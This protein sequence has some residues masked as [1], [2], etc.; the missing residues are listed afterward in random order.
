[1][2]SKFQYETAK[3]QV[4]QKLS[5]VLKYGWPDH[6][7]QLPA[8]LTPYF[9]FRQEITEANRII[10]KGEQVT[11]PST[12][13]MNMKEK[14]H[15]RRL[16]IKKCKSRARETLF[17][18]GMNM[19]ITEM[20]KGCS[21]CQEHRKYQQKEPLMPHNLPTKPGTQDRKPT[22]S[23]KSQILSILLFDSHHFTPPLR[24]SFTCFLFFLFFRLQLTTTINFSM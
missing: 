11:V 9:P 24:L 7:A 17:W 5:N 2:L 12:M 13:R 18:P 15:D 20:I 3:G 19:K 22:L 8:E 6:K 10:M 14:I 16:G 21:L 4:L 1:M 23:Q